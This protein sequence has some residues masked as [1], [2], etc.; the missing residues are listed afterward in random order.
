MS[1]TASRLS[2]LKTS[3]ETPALKLTSLVREIRQKAGLSGTFSVTEQLSALGLTSLDMVGLMI[4]VE[5]EF[6]IAIPAEEITPANFRSIASIE[7]L[8]HRIVSAGAPGS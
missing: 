6:G 7:A 3:E 8:V 1:A 2:A 5:A 4:A